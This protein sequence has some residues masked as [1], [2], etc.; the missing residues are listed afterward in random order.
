[1]IASNKLHHSKVHQGEQLLDEQSP[2]KGSV[3]QLGLV[4]EAEREQGK[5][6]R[7]ETCLVLWNMRW[8]EKVN[9]SRHKVVMQEVGKILIPSSYNHRSDERTET[10]GQ[11]TWS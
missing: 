8:G 9:Q 1:L 5:N 4:S 11:T 3:K 6:I 2:Q 10:I 7:Q